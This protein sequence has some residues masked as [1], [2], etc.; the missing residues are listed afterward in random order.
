MRDKAVEVINKYVKNYDLSNLHCEF[1]YSPST[2][3]LHLHIGLGKENENDG[4]QRHLIHNFSDVIRNLE[5]DSEYYT[6][7]VLINVINESYWKIELDE[8]KNLNSVSI[9]KKYNSSTLWEFFQNM[10]CYK[11]YN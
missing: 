11:N 8:Y 2:Y 1:H 4:M 10:D 3:H 9:T 6:K 7:P 5:T